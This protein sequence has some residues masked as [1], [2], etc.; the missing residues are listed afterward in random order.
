[1]GFWKAVRDRRTYLKKTYEPKRYIFPCVFFLM[2]YQ[3]ASL[4][5]VQPV[6]GIYF[7]SWRRVPLNQSIST[8]VFFREIDQYTREIIQ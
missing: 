4:S 5:N 8:P 6:M 3:Q 1:M 2:S 7:F